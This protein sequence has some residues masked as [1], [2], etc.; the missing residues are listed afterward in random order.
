[1]IKVFRVSLMFIITLAFAS[2][3]FAQ[4]F[5]QV[6]YPGACPGT[7]FLVGGPNLEGTSV[8]SY[9]D[10]D[11]CGVLH[12]FALTAKGAFSTF[13]PPGSIFTEPS[14]INLQGV[15]VGLYLDSSSVSHGFILD[16]G[17]YSFVDVKGAAGTALSGINDLG[18][19]SGVTCTDPACGNTGNANTSH[20]FV[21]SP[22]GGFTFFDPPGAV[23]SNTATVSLTG[24]IVGFYTDGS[25]G[26]HGYLLVRGKYTIIDYPTA[27][28]ATFATGGNLQNHI[29]GVYFD[30]AG[31]AHGFLLKD[32][33]YTSFDY[34]GAIFT[35]A[36]GIN[37]FD[38]IVG[39]YIDANN[40]TH[41]F[42]RTP[43]D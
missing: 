43:R 32:G 35:E 17:K 14:F 34:P 3:A 29:V 42:I 10:A 21:R 26:T 1:M 30:S 37:I 38:V 12:G 28:G 15:I 23:S 6:D 41:G 25:G 36:T 18:E 8:G 2:I 40:L 11:A 20:S 33:A 19:I 7:T 22:F 13:D 39:F 24:A 9:G 4:T 27:V 31:V 5:A 16:H